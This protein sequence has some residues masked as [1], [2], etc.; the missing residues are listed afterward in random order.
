[1]NVMCA[2][3]ICSSS[4]AVA[5]CICTSALVTLLERHA[6]CPVLWP[7]AGEVSGAPEVVARPC[8]GAEARQDVEWLHSIWLQRL[9]MDVE[10]TYET[11]HYPPRTP[12]SPC[13]RDPLH[14]INRLLSWRNLGSQPHFEAERSFRGL[15][16]IK[17]SWVSSR[18]TPCILIL[19]SCT[20]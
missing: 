5:E 3:F 13:H 19:C 9:W 12:T 20:P 1:M 18:S 14:R 2:P 15:S 16:S 11:C 17:L 10:G 4:D 6:I 7:P 8:E